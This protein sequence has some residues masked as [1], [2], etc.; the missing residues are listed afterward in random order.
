MLDETPEFEDVF[1]LGGGGGRTGFAPGAVSVDMEENE[2]PRA[3]EQL[4]GDVADQVAAL[5]LIA[6]KLAL[7]EVAAQGLSRA[8]ALRRLE[9]DV[10]SLARRID[11]QEHLLRQRGE[12]VVCAFAGVLAEDENGAASDVR[13][14]QSPRVRRISP[15]CSMPTR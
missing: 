3:L 7:P 8:L 4:C 1:A 6:G 11:E 12:G 9:A 10:L 5:R 15:T 13:F 14:H 2:A